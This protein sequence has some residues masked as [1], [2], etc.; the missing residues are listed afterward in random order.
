MALE[1]KRIGD[2]WHAYGTV[3]GMRV[4]RSLKTRD[5]AIA[6]E[7]RRAMELAASRG[8]SL[9]SREYFDEVVDAYLRSKKRGLSEGTMSDVRRLL[10]W[11]SD[12]KIGLMGPSMILEKIDKE[13]AHCKPS[14]VRKTLTILKAI[15]AFGAERGWCEP[16]EVKR[17]KDEGRR[18]RW[19]TD[20]ELR[21][22]LIKAPEYLWPAYLFLAMTGARAGEV[23]ALD[24]HDV[25]KTEDPETGAETWFVRLRTK[26]G[27]EGIV[28]ERN[29]PLNPRAL[30]ALVE[31]ARLN[32]Q[33]GVPL[34]KRKGPIF[35]NML[36]YRLTTALL[37]VRVP[38]IAKRAGIRDVQLHDLRRTFAS[39]LAQR[40]TPLPVVAE[41]LG[42]EGL[43]QVQRYAHF[44]SD[45]KR[46]AVSRL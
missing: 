46:V 13:M 31:A 29:V 26:K 14:T 1:L 37:S 38:E 23:C 25:W 8:K 3:N 28:R 11:F 41:L 34:A 44:A 21:E 20:E 42:H 32:G 39:K 15:F 17:P 4:R 35:R 7:K 9:V 5:R 33:K 16:L 19:L 30:D 12:K 36:G 27:Q 6:H 45:S 43:A 2:V 40:G 24:W 18:E 22:F 10:D